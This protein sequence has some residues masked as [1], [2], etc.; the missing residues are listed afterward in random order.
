MYWSFDTTLASVTAHYEKL[1]SLAG[2]EKTTLV[3][4]P[5]S[6]ALYPLAEMFKETPIKLG[7][8][9]CSDHAKGAFT[10]QISA[11]SLRSLCCSYSII[12]HSERRQQCKESSQQVADKCSQLLGAGI[13]PIVCIGETL[14]AHNDGKTLIALEEQLR[15]VLNFAKERAHALDNSTIILAYE[16]VWAIGSD[17]TPQIDHVDTVFAWLATITQKEAPFVHWAFLYGG[18]VTSQNVQNFK[19]IDRMGG[20]LIGRASLDFQELEKVVHCS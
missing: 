10:G 9:D 20:F 17:K 3:L 7:A 14:D 5:S 4:C 13:T 18:N 8:Q 16:P 2:T 12:G 19:K 11:E 15:P 6:P 1:I